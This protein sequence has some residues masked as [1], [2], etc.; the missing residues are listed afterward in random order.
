MP[1][2]HC[3]EFSPY[4]LYGPGKSLYYIE[5]FTYYKLYDGYTYCDLY[6]IQYIVFSAHHPQESSF[7]AKY[8]EYIFVGVNIFRGNYDPK[9]Y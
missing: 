7:A 4:R 1:L 5:T 2:S 8:G 9:V 3:S 6:S